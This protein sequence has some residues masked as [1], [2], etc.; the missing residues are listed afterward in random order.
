MNENK[1]QFHKGDLVWFLPF[2]KVVADSH[3]YDNTFI[4]EI[5][6]GMKED[7]PHRVY[8]KK[9]G[10]IQVEVSMHWFPE[11]AFSRTDPYQST[12]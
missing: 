11:W 7:N 9:K 12:I 2:D 10:L 6:E 1:H 5:W 4:R 8:S 3:Q